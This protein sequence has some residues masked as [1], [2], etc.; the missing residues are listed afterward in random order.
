MLVLVLALVVI[1]VLILLIVIL[2]VVFVLVVVSVLI[3]HFK[4][5]LFTY[6]APKGAEYVWEFFVYQLT[7]PP[8][9]PSRSS[10]PSAAMVS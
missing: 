4:F 3:F 1:F 9:I 7:L 8:F 6:S 10:T 2:V 5:P